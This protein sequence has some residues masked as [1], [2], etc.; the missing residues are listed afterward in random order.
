[1]DRMLGALAV[2]GLIASSASAADSLI[3]LEQFANAPQMSAPQMSP[4]GKHLVYIASRQGK[5]FIAT[6]D[7]A[8]KTVRPAL[9]GES[10]RYIVRWCGFKNEE[11]ILCSYRGVEYES[12]RP[13]GTSRLVA[14]NVD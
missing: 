11:R 12:G 1:M 7:F 10:G 5:A 8:S 9:S 14:M 2:L 4:D 3:P 13:Y 6:Y